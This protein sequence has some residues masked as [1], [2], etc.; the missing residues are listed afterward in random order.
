MNIFKGF[1]HKCCQIA[2]QKD[3]AIQTIFGN[4]YSS[5]FS[6]SLLVLEMNFYN[7]ASG[8]YYLI[9]LICAELLLMTERHR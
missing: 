7:L 4:S 2:F 3:V 9:V 6:V 5:Y 8:K 1:G